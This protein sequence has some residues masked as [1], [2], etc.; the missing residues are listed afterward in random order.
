[1]TL[2]IALAYR[3]GM[4]VRVKHRLLKGVSRYLSRGEHAHYKFGIL[5]M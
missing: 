4:I 3:M 1:M 2:T 5:L